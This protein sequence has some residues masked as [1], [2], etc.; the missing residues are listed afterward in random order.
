MERVKNTAMLERIMTIHIQL[1]SFINKIRLTKRCF[2]ASV[3]VLT[4]GIYDKR[5]MNNEIYTMDI[6]TMTETVTKTFEN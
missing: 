4:T 1:D 6:Q 3:S 5:Q 2:Q